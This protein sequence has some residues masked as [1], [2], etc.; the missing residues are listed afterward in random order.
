MASETKPKVVIEA[1]GQDDRWWLRMRGLNR[2]WLLQ[3]PD[4]FADRAEA[5]RCAARIAKTGISQGFE[6]EVR[7][8]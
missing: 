7:D 3:L 1:Y 2:W 6:V 5:R 4:R 8:A